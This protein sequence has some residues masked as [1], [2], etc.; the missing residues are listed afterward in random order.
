M[1][2]EKEG[3]SI[4]TVVKVSDAEK[5]VLVRSFEI[6]EVLPCLTTPGYIRFTAHADR[7]IGEVIPI[8]FLS[9][10]PGKANYSPGENSLTLNIYNRLITFFADGKVGVTNTPD[11]EGAKEILKVIGGIINDAYKKY[12]KYGKPSGEEIEKARSLSWLDIYNCLP[13]TNCGECGYQVCSSFAVSVLQGNVKL[14]KC[15]LLSDPKYRANLEELKRK[16]GRRLFEAL[17]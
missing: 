1:K 15:T 17:F 3:R 11:I 7:E 12:L 8:I 16:M 9:Y 14:S 2:A 4:V 5:D 13:K 10:P 6:K